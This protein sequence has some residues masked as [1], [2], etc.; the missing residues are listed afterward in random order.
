M[1]TLKNIFNLM[2][3][4]LATV[5]LLPILII[6]FLVFIIVFPI[7]WMYTRI[8]T[9]LLI[10]KNNSKIFFI[11]ADYNNY[12][13]SKHFEQREEIVYIR[14]SDHYNNSLMVHALTKGC[15]TKR[16]PM[17]V[18]IENGQLIKKIHFGSF[19]HFYKRNQ[20]IDAFFTLIEKSIQ[21]LNH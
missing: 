9:H 4:I 7:N 14:V 8:K 11:S 10:R 3:V 16:F 1:K 21:N 17:L 20:N 13:F 2:I 18:K 19:K 15:S 6:V 5:V 12:N